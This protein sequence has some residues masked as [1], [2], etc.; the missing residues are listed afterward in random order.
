MLNI[1]GSAFV[2]KAPF[3]DLNLT[4][5][6]KGLVFICGKKE[7]S[8]KDLIKYIGGVEYLPGL[9]IQI[10]D[11]ILDDVKKLD[12]YRL[13][14][15]GFIFGNVQYI[16]NETILANVLSSS[17]LFAE[18]LDDA[19]VDECL[20]KVGLLEH[21]NCL[22]SELSEYELHCLD[23]ARALVKDPKVLLANNPIARLNAEETEK[24]WNIIEK[25]SNE[26]LV[27]VGNALRA[28]AKEIA[29]TI[30]S[31]EANEVN[32]VLIENIEVIPNIP[33]KEQTSPVAK[34]YEKANK[35][36]FK[37]LFNISSSLLK[38]G[39]FLICLLTITITL[40]LTSA[41]VTNNSHAN[42]AKTLH[43]NNI[44]KVIM[45]RNTEEHDLVI[46]QAVRDRLDSEFSELKIQWGYY[47]SKDVSEQGYKAH[48]RATGYSYPEALFKIGEDEKD[49][50]YELIHGSW[51]DSETG[52]YISESEAQKYINYIN[53]YATSTRLH[54]ALLKALFDK[55][56]P[57]GKKF[58]NIQELIGE[59]LVLAYNTKNLT[60]LK[61]A[62]IFKDNLYS[63][64]LIIRDN[65]TF[66]NLAPDTPAFD[67][68]K[69]YSLG[70]VTL[71]DDVEYNTKFLNYSATIIRDERESLIISTELDG[72]YSVLY[73]EISSLVTPLNIFALI[74]VVLTIAGSIIYSVLLIAN[75]RKELTLSRT[76]G[77]QQKEI[78]K[79]SVILNSIIVL[80]AL[81]AS[82]IIA[83]II[84]VIYNIVLK[85]KYAFLAISYLSIPAYAIIIAILGAI[86]FAA[87]FI[88][89]S[90][91]ALKQNDYLVY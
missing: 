57:E 20:D 80:I 32:H 87:V 65:F 49:T 31:F 75:Y 1:K 88:A 54:A 58:N 83:I 26:Y 56:Y 8:A 50:T 39:I 30:V 36:S 42:F 14:N 66:P 82:I 24:I 89:L 12:D 11:F 45:M 16:E 78:I 62:G 35:F 37:N 53:E 86:V 41:S 46:S 51:D 77:L 25:L 43:D 63:N 6:D 38:G 64:N 40:F 4:F 13:H 22:V 71:T 18:V 73:S 21:K 61:V 7:S 72:E 52:I 68:N 84:Q 15:I 44:K 10:D 28:K 48:A 23:I 2:Q 55:V 76:Y 81:I 33:Y 47:L 9:N 34:H 69:F 79:V 59:K 60:V 90:I 27:I 85:G 3:K 67:Q 91:K 74:F 5:G 70:V 17:S 29:N 19:Y